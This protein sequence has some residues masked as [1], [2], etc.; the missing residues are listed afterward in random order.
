MLIPSP[1][2][3]REV[4]VSLGIPRAL[5][6]LL[7]SGILCHGGRSRCGRAHGLSYCEA[8]NKGQQKAAGRDRVSAPP[9]S[10]TLGNGDAQRA[11]TSPDVNSCDVNSVGLLNGG[12]GEGGMEGG[13]EGGE[14]V[15]DTHAIH[16]R[17]RMTVRGKG[18]G[19][20]LDRG[21]LLDL[22]HG[23][24]RMTKDPRIPTCTRSHAWP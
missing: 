13:R 5:A 9:P 1:L 19:G 23:P 4:F 11:K 21:D 16:G 17:S 8:Q 10:D 20:G 2:L 12:G 6:G 14:C 24:S 22:M 15:E 3:D 7:N 18:G